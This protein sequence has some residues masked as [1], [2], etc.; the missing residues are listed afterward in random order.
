MGTN[1]PKM[2]IIQVALRHSPF[3]RQEEL[4]SLI[5]DLC[6]KH[7]VVRQ[8]VESFTPTVPVEHML[9]EISKAATLISKKLPW[10]KYGRGNQDS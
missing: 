3:Q 4:V 8:D 10:D 5:G 9:T 7:P 2:L 6:R 1:K